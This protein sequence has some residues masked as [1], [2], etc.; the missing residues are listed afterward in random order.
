MTRADLQAAASDGQIAA[1]RRCIRQGESNQ[2]DGAYTLINGGGHFDSFARHPWD[3]VPTT[4]GSRACGAYQFLGTTWAAL[5]EKYGFETFTPQEQDEGAVALILEH[6]AAPA[7]RAGDL[8][9]ACGLLHSTWTSLPGGSEQNQSLAN[10]ER[11]FVR[12]GGVLPTTVDASEPHASTA[13]PPV[14]PTAAT[15]QPERPPM[16]ALAIP[17]LTSILPAVIGLFSGKAQTQISKATGASPDAAAAFLQN[18]MAQV[19]NV[20]Q[21]PITDQRSAIQAVAAVTAPDA[22]QKIADL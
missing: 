2:D 4:H 10:I 6:G 19:G 8:G 18:L 22:T 15:P 17:F 13:T 5:R 7:I 12:Y 9:T 1:F 11:V 21:V 14:T 3:G 20:A 16:G